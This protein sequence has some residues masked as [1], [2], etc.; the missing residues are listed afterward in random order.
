MFGRDS[1]GYCK[2]QFAWL[3]TTDLPYE[4]LNIEDDA[5]AKALFNELTA[6]HELTKVTP[7]TVVGER[8]SQMLDFHF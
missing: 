4:Y 3:E 6:K 2:A 7:I 8:V 5:E 1:C